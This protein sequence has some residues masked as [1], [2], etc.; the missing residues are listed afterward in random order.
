MA[1]TAMRPVL[2]ADNSARQ[3]ETALAAAAPTAVPWVARS[4]TR[5]EEVLSSLTG[6]TD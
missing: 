6:R 1:S 3:R 2:P 5:I 4:L